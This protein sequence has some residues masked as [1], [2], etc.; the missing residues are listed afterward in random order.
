[1]CIIW[2]LQVLWELLAGNI[3]H[4]EVETREETNEVGSS[5]S[6]P[7]LLRNEWG[8]EPAHLAALQELG[9]LA[10]V[11]NTSH[12]GEVPVQVVRSM[13]VSLIAYLSD[14]C[15]YMS[16]NLHALKQ[17]CLFLCS[18]RS[19]VV[20]SEFGAL[21][22]LADRVRRTKLDN[23]KHL[24]E[25]LG[26]SCENKEQVDVAGSFNL[27]SAN[28]LPKLK[29]ILEGL[30]SSHP[31]DNNRV[32]SKGDMKNQES[33]EHGRNSSASIGNELRTDHVALHQIEESQEKAPW[34]GPAPMPEFAGG[35]GMPNPNCQPLVGETPPKALSKH[36][37]FQT[38]SVKHQSRIQHLEGSKDLTCNI[39][40]G[41]LLE[42][43]PFA[44]LTHLLL[45]V[46]T[47]F[48]ILSC[49]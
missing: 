35:R 29:E 10:M 23:I 36:Q 11:S 48:A 12:E 9:K 44:I 45:S 19:Q 47:F 2:Y 39:I 32:D 33:S 4:F 22:L 24:R 31:V 27:I 16:R 14:E 3:V 38:T 25:K 43:D 18:V 20:L 13:F 6:A 7:V 34:R 46:S 17:E 49:L 41:D 1:M 21:L 30:F 8:G 28:V 42:V 5:S 15:N 40:D 26:L 37:S